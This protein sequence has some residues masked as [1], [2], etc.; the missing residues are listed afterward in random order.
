[1][2]NSVSD[3]AS[4][5]D[6]GHRDR[7]QNRI[8]D[9]DYGSL[10]ST[11]QQGPSGTVYGAGS[12]V[13]MRDVNQP[14]IHKVLALR[15]EAPMYRTMDWGHPLALER[16]E[17]SMPRRLDV[18][19]RVTDNQ[20]YYY[21]G[22][23][24]P[25]VSY[26]NM[27]RGVARG[28]KLI[29]PSSLGTDRLFLMGL[30]STAI[31]K[32][33]PDVPDFSLPRF[34]GELR[35]GLPKVPLTII[36]SGRKAR[37]VGSEYLNYQF[38]LMPTISDLQKLFE[39]LMSPGA[40]DVV[41]NNLDREFRVR[42]VLAKGETTVNTDLTFTSEMYTSFYQVSRRNKVTSSRT[43]SYRI[44][45]SCSFKY[46]QVRRLNQLIT[47]LEQQLGMGVIPTL[48][49]FWNLIP[50]SWFVDWFTNLN[51]VITNLSYLGKDG[52]H[53]QRGYIMGTYVDAETLRHTGT[54]NGVP[55]E[56]IGTV[57]YERK[58]RV[59][60]SPFGFG[61]TWEDFDPFQMSILAALGISKL[62]F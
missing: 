13:R 19:N 49:D 32:S 60:A 61:L 35:Q 21:K 43:Q 62:R 48:I 42:K 30:G 2:G 8:T 1:M 40:K 41:E 14:H 33:I 17:I 25:T 28:E 54:I 51:D 9:S 15:R 26:G 3:W 34:I 36:G 50:W 4:P 7:Y 37:D 12:Q 29:I 47:D 46:F 22:V 56:T 52:L 44:W 59:K 58:Y 5:S 45:S 23:A 38:G 16:A 10:W 18:K 27:M 39:L 57:R 6:W 55:F 20:D 31:A 53:L 11:G 24:M